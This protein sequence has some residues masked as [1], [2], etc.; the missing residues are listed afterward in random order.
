MQDFSMAARGGPGTGDV[1]TW[2]VLTEEGGAADANQRRVRPPRDGAPN[3][4]PDWEGGAAEARPAGG[5]GLG[6]GVVDA[7]PKLAAAGG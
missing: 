5:L 7:A 2:E 1:V 6:V 3:P 4:E